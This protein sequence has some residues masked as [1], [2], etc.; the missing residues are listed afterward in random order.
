MSILGN[1]RRTRK[2][3]VETSQI[4]SPRYNHSMKPCPECL[5]E[6]PDPAMVCHACGKRIVGKPCPDCAETNKQEATKCSFCGHNFA[7]ERRVAAVEPFH[8]KA[9]LLPTFLIRRR[10]IPQEIRLTSEKIQILTYGIFWLSRTDD[11][12]PWEKIAGYHYRSGLFWDAVEIQTRG[13][14]ANHITCL[15]KSDGLKVKEILERMKE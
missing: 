7:R 10:L 13:Q 6:V 12:I 5:T 8:A 4:T 11:E 15:R 2:T 14:K 9:E 1:K 3:L